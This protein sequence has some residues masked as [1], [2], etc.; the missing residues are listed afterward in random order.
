MPP[1]ATLSH[2]ALVPTQTHREQHSLLPWVPEELD[3]HGPMEGA[4]GGQLDDAV[5]HNFLKFQVSHFPKAAQLIKNQPAMQETLVQFL[6][7]EVPLE[8]DRLPTPVFF[9]ENPHGQR[10]LV[11][12]SRWGSQRIGIRM[13]NQAQVTLK[14]AASPRTQQ[15]QVH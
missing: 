4:E 6:G 7:W 15:E 3:L 8:R 12:Y 5:C 14:D 11:G 2:S 9:L 1:A 13:S 10:S